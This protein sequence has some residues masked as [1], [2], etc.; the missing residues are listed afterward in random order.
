MPPV[1]A[2]GAIASRFPDAAYRQR[3]GSIA[4]LQVTS[5]ERI[6]LMNGLDVVREHKAVFLDR[7]DA[8]KF[9]AASTN[10]VVSLRLENAL[11]YLYLEVCWQAPH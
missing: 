2:A 4:L 10:I 7:F 1:V 9:L 5:A 6:A 11:N 8:P 3:P